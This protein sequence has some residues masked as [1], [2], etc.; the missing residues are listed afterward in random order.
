M[1]QDRVS[2]RTDLR[3]KAERFRDLNRAGG[4]ILP[5]A[6]DAVSAAV[7]AAAGF[8][9]IATTS[10][11]VA[12]A[13]GYA[14]AELI[15]RDAMVREIALIARTVSVPV[16]ADIEAGY[17]PDIAD[18]S[19][20][21]DA[22]I[23]AGAVGVNL[24]DAVYPSGGDAPLFT[25][26]EAAARIAAARARADATDIPLVINA[27]TD[28]FLL[29]LG[30]SDDER[31]AMAIERGRA[32]HGAGGDVIFLPGLLDPALI[33]RATDGI[34][35]PISLMAGRSS[36][37]AAELFAAGAHRLSVG[38]AMMLAT[39]GLLRT[40]ADE[41]QG[42]GTWSTIARD[43]YSWGDAETLFTGRP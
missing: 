5:N 19:D 15:G 17:G 28:V 25:V 2:N 9:A 8:P 39:M 36:P 43:L 23:D 10:A 41:I 40:I 20:T 31:L 12:F 35:A 27:R 24:E 14:D 38:P 18:V 13:R 34:G 3:A 42:S 22:V 4:L 11:G 37:A 29:G 6:W 26:D 1:G 30:D 16:S 33:R 21:I 32:Y 7:L